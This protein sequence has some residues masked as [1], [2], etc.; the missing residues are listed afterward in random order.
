MQSIEQRGISAES[1][2]K[3][4]DQQTVD[5]TQYFFAK[6]RIVYG[7]SKFDTYWPTDTEVRQVKREW[8]EQIGR[9]TR[10]EIDNAMDHAKRM[11]YEEDWSW[12]NVGLILSGAKRFASHKRFLPNPV[13]EVIPPAERSIRVRALMAEVFA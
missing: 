10:E 9:L 2:R 3:I 12:P 5:A 4:F 6:L 1:P 7:A 11:M 8:A 13:R